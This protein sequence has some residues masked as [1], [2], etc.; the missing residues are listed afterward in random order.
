[1]LFV[2][3]IEPVEVVPAEPDRSG[4][5]ST[6]VEPTLAKAVLVVGG[7][8]GKRSPGVGVATRWAAQ[9]DPLNV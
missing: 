6:P 7:E 5:F 3:E 9:I 8:L 2:K 1:M 4:Q